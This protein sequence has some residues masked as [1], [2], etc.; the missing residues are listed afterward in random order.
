MGVIVRSSLLRACFLTNI[1]QVAAED[2]GWGRSSGWDGAAWL[3]AWV[4][5]AGPSQVC[6]S[7]V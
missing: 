2:P 7:D 6:S 3:G 1:G 5:L 4:V